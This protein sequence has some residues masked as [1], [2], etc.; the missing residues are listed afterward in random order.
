[1][2]KYLALIIG[3]C[4]VPSLFAQNLAPNGNYEAFTLCPNAYGQ[5]NRASSWNFVTGHTGTTDYFNTCGPSP[6][7]TLSAFWGAQTP[8]SGNGYIGGLTYHSSL[9]SGREYAQAQLTSPLVAGQVYTVTVKAS[10]G[11]ICNFATIIQ[12][13]FSNAPVVVSPSSSAAITSV[14]PQ[15]T[16]ATI[17]TNKTGWTNLTY[18]YTALGGEQYVILGNFKNDAATVLTPV[19]GGTSNQTYYYYD[20]FSVALFT[21]LPI[22]LVGFEANCIDGKTMLNWSTSSELNNDYFTVETS[23]DGVEYNRLLEIPGAGNSNQLNH[24]YATVHPTGSAE[25]YFR[26]SQTDYDGVSTTY[27]PIV[28]ICNE[29]TIDCPLAYFDGSDCMVK[30]TSG[31]TDMYTITIM[32][33]KGSMILSESHRLEKGQHELRFPGAQ[34]SSGV[35]IVQVHSSTMNCSKRIVVCR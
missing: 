18:N 5:L 20:D 3:C 4:F 6:V 22:E 30:L 26:L 25:K 12:V 11:E 7:N 8:A 35:Y 29:Q 2:P 31:K 10:L 23:D 32:D 27:A 33:C 24:Y 34:L 1:M 15:V 21:P 9:P 14:T 28:S 13:Y 16:F 17:A 19:A